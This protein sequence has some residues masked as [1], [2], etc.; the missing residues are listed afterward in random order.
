LGLIELQ[1]LGE[2]LKFSGSINSSLSHSSYWTEFRNNADVGRNKGAAPASADAAA[3]LS[4]IDWGG[5]CWIPLG[6]H[7]FHAATVLVHPAGTEGLRSGFL[8]LLCKAQT[9]VLQYW[10]VRHGLEG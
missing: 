3:W 7:V 8:I 6:H 9:R 2:S 1:E 4:N 10:A 5:V